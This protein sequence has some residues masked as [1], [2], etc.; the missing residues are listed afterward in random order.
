MST[1][2]YEEE[3]PCGGK[4]VVEKNYWKISYYFSGPDLRYS[5]AFFA[6]SGRDVSGYINAYLKNWQ[7]FND[8]FNQIPAGSEL[9][10]KGERDMN[11]RIGGFNEGV[12]LHSYHMPIRT[13]KE[14][15][16]VLESY[17]Y[18]QDRAPKIQEFLSVL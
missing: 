8:L 5:G 7:T 14:L 9:T 16:N 2:K 1:G 6:I 4:L 11:I 3:L 18:A 13:E 12:C 15:A 17:V 10:K